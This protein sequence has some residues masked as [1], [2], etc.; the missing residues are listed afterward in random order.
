MARLAHADPK[1]IFLPFHVQVRKVKFEVALYE[2]LR[3]EHNIMA[4]NLLNYCILVEQVGPRLDVPQDIIGRCVLLLKRA[5][6]ENIQWWDLSTK[7]RVCA[8]ATVLLN[9]IIFFQ[10][11]L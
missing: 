10:D 3:S 1:Y 6:G 7:E 9:Q 8:H 5:H 2:L 4:S 11:F